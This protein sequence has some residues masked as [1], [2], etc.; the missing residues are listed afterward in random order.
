MGNASAEGNEEG[1]PAHSDLTGAGRGS[2]QQEAATLWEGLGLKFLYLG[3]I[4]IAT[5]ITSRC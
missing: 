3:P 1:F 5:T 2:G 4:I